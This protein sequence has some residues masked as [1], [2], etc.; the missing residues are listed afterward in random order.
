MLGR[1]RTVT[2]FTTIPL[3]NVAQGYR[4]RT[5]RDQSTSNKNRQWNGF[6][7]QGRHGSQ[8][9]NGMGRRGSYRSVHSTIPHGTALE[10]DNLHKKSVSAQLE[11]LKERL[12]AA[13]RS[14]KKYS[15]VQAA[16]KNPS[17]KSSAGTSILTCRVPAKELFKYGD[18]IAIEAFAS[19]WKTRRHCTTVDDNGHVKIRSKQRFWQW[20]RRG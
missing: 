12:K 14:I 13:S 4:G 3:E 5:S 17:T 9:R 19:N 16:L 18:S 8:H 1:L 11:Q 7:T 20:E 10:K 6:R 15:K 2:N